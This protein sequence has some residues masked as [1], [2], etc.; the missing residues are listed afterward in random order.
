LLSKTS[1]GEPDLVTTPVAAVDVESVC[2]LYDVQA[3][4]DEG[5]ALVEK[6]NRLLRDHG[7]EPTTRAEFL[8]TYEAASFYEGMAYRDYFAG[9][10]SRGEAVAFA[11]GGPGEDIDRPA[12]DHR[13]VGWALWRLGGGVAGFEHVSYFPL[14][15]A[16]PLADDPRTE[17]GN[18]AG[19]LIY[20]VPDPAGGSKPA[21]S[22]RLKILREAAEDFA[23][24]SLLRDT[25]MAAYADEL[26]AGVVPI[27]P[28]PGGGAVGAAAFDE[29]R[30]AAAVA[31]VK[32]RWGQGIAENVVR[33]KAVS[34]EGT[35]VPEATVRVGPTA[36]VT[37][38]EGEY[39]LRHVPRGRSLVATAPGYERAGSSGAGGRGD[40]YMKR[41]LRRGVLNFDDTTADVDDKNLNLVPRVDGNVVGGPTLV[42]RVAAD[43]PGVLKFRPPLSDWRTF[44]AFALELY[45]GAGTRVRATVRVEDAAGAFYEEVF[46]VA[47]EAWTTARVDVVAAA[48]RRYLEPK[49]KGGGLSF[50]EEPAVDFSRVKGVEIEI[51]SPTAGE[52]RLGRVWLEAA[53]E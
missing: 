20:A 6:Y 38:R 44:S 40:F 11:P 1:E 35:P 12:S 51:A 34:D 36:A 48:G 3:D 42:G 45:G 18:G 23:Y 49:G 25:D 43:K 13:L 52:F 29:G 47:P 19:A 22:L 16:E 50:R 28:T 5:R 41:V 8:S 10:L 27:M 17:M 2:R 4:S 31:L 46:Y 15:N 37:D 24:L 32:S 7:F 21:P 26:A 14:K 9:K 39:E 53:G 30:N 33:G